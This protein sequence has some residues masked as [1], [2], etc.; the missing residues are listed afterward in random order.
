MNRRFLVS[1][2][3]GLSLSAESLIAGE[4]RFKLALDEVVL[5]SQR[6]RRGAN[7]PDP[8]PTPNSGV[9]RRRRNSSD[10]ES[11]AEPV[12]TPATTRSRKGTFQFEDYS[13]P[14]IMYVGM[15]A[16][17]WE[18]IEA[19]STAAATAFQDLGNRP[20]SKP[21]SASA[22]QATGA[23]PLIYSDVSK[24]QGPAPFTQTHEHLQE[25]MQ[26]LDRAS[27]YIADGIAFMDSDSIERAT[28]SINLSTESIHLAVD[29][30]PIQIPDRSIVED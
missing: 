2:I 18:L 4:A 19:A 28:K 17:W 24:F 6:T 22:L 30:L 23:W 11:T 27:L 14:Q 8:T 10:S 3:A 13:D 29:A 1:A 20:S 16:T 25:A 5:A 21:A 12:E 9:R 7:D 15:L 26:N